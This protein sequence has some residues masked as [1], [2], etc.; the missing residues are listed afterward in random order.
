MTYDIAVIGCGIAGASIAF[1]LSK[2]DLK[3]AVFEKENDVSCGTTKANSAIMHA[4]FD[5]EP[6]T[7][8]AKLNVEGSKLAEKLCADLSVLY[9]KI[10]SL[11]LSFDED[12]KLNNL[13]ER[14][15][16]NGV[17][18]LEIWN[19][20]RIFKN[21]LNLNTAVT[22]AL[23]AP[24]AA[25]V[26]PWDLCISQIETAVKNGVKLFLNCKIDKIEKSEKL[27]NLQTNGVSYNAEYIINCSGLYAD[28]IHNLV[29]P[30]KE[31]S[32]FPNKGE[33]F[34]LD[35]SQS[36]L[37]N[38]II[39]QMPSDKGKGVLVSPTVHGNLIA[40][41]D[42][43]Y[44]DSKDNLAVTS[45]GLSF[46]SETAKKSVPN[47]NF[48][49]NIRNFTGL[50]AYSS[51]DDFIIRKSLFAD[52]F[53]NVAGIKSP[54]LTSAIAI[55]HYVRDML[56]DMGVKLKGKPD[57]ISKR[58][59]I[60]FKDLS[61]EMKNE[62]ISKDPSYGRIICR[63]ETI[64]EAEIKN[65][66][67]SDIPPVSLDGVKRRT[68]AGMGRCQGG[69]CSPKILPLISQELNISPQ[70]VMQENKGSHILTGYT[71]Q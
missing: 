15:L 67:H 56:G 29:S 20:D 47:I 44:C 59:K 48:S 28:E 13:Y 40:G 14:G 42:S 27:Y 65:T 16:K 54:G 52:N 58:E 7:L 62:Y 50:R 61:P 71:K 26:D 19:R 34:L 9:K 8:M 5:N 12:I 32:I 1:E 43:V 69:F 33:Y 35:K 24:T 37:V 55:A 4:G 46:V 57:F 70:D 45:S 31:F 49:E 64:S 68:C 3:V 11:I 6:G 53:I 30:E 22:G 66:L 25:I 60:V 63:C 23:Y 41:P 36:S 21:E 51:E 38:H 2:Y 17:P 18:G 10:G 39:F